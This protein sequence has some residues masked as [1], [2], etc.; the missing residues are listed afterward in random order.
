MI[1]AGPTVQRPYDG[2]HDA[3]EPPAPLSVQPR[4]NLSAPKT[5]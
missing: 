2:T 1:S 4:A 3:D 5:I